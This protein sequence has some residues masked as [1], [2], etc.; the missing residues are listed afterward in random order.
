MKHVLLFLFLTFSIYSTTN[1]QEKNEALNYNFSYIGDA[2]HNF[3]G[4][5]KTGGTYVGMAN[6]SL[7]FDTETAG[8][9]KGGTFFA[10]AMN[11]HGES[12]SDEYIGDYQY[13]SNIDG[14]VHTAMMELWYS[15]TYKDFEFIVGLQDVFNSFGATNNG[16]L[17]LNTSFAFIPTIWTNMP[18]PCFPL[19][20]L[21]FT[22]KWDISEHFTWLA[23]IYDGN[24][25]PFD[26]NKYNFK[27]SLSKDDGAFVISELQ[28]TFGDNEDHPSA[29]K[30]G[31]YNNDMTG[32]YANMDLH[33]Y[34]NASSSLDMFS[35]VGYCADDDCYADYYAGAGLNYSGVFTDEGTDAL[36][37]SFNFVHFNTLD[38]SEK[39]IE[40][41]YQYNI[42]DHLFI[43][44][45][46]QYI[47]DP[48]GGIDYDDALA[49][50]VR[51]GF[52]F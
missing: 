40:L 45:D 52:S 51:F 29:V 22:F 36:G 21:G 35:Q 47:M 30:L 6:F 8:F 16:G 15:Q 27:Y 42:D 1:A 26:D 18:T 43:Q 4:G 49:C 25:T 3:T 20:E 41:T 37:L 23:A 7:S 48:R 11:L 39:V 44:P 2:M 46:V 28:Y 50:F 34:D 32:V 38:A 10:K 9:W 33:L 14:G 24:P 13:A 31:A 19:T 12:P 17:Y 5:I